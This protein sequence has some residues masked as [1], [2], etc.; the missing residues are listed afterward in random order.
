MLVAASLADGLP[1][2]VSLALTLTTGAAVVAVSRRFLCGG[3]GGGA[4]TRAVSGAAGHTAVL[5]CGA[6]LSSP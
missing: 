1:V 4:L 6:G 3:G 5:K 2:A